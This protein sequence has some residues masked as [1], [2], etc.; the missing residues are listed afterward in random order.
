MFYVYKSLF[1]TRSKQYL[2]GYVR[3][4]GSKLY[5]NIKYESW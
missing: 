2:Y 3:V 5:K 1:W 4:V